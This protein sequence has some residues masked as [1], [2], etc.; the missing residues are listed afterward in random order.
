MEG[1]SWECNGWSMYIFYYLTTHCLAS[2]TVYK[3]HVLKNLIKMYLKNWLAL[4]AYNLSYLKKI[5]VTTK[6]KNFLDKYVHT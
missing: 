5:Q 4:L 3:V 2:S 1:V 6:I